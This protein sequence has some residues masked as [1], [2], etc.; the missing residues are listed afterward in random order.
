MFFENINFLDKNDYTDLYDIEQGFMLGNM[1]KK[2]YIGYKNYKPQQ[3]IAKS[4]KDVLMLK[5]YQ[6]D[7]AIND[8]SLYLDLHPEDNDVYIKFREYTNNLNYL[9]SSYESTY[10]PLELNDSDYDN[11]MWS[12]GNWPFDGGNK[13]V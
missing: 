1:F 8:L 2:E 11:Y 9:I 5:I 4:D 7:F 3:L 10:G 12:C 6:Y 13:N